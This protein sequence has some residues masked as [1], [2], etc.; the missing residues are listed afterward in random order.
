[1]PDSTARGAACVSGTRDFALVIP[2]TGPLMP[3]DVLRVYADGVC[4]GET[5]VD[6][7]PVALA[8]WF[9]DEFTPAATDGRLL[10]YTV[11]RRGVETTLAP[12]ITGYV[13]GEP[14]APLTADAA[15]HVALTPPT[16]VPRTPLAVR[17][18][19]NPSP[20]PVLMLPEAARVTVY[21]VLGQ[22][23]RAHV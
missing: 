2:H 6:T 17:T 18:R 8:V 21:D 20:A 22:I 15:W 7:A 16:A 11:T 23:G 14:G 5:T 10:R 3:G 1:P 12:R 13:I 19:S 4:V 9:S